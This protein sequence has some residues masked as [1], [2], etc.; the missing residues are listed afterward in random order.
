MAFGWMGM[1]TVVIATILSSWF[2]RRRG[3]AISLAF[4]GATFGGIVIAPMLVL[5]V[6]AIGFTGAMLTATAVM[7]AFLLPTIVWLID[8]PVSANTLFEP[9]AHQAAT[10]NVKAISANRSRWLLLRNFGFWTVCAPFA[11]DAG[12]NRLYRAPDCNLGANDGPLACRPRGRGHHHHGRDR[13]SL[14][15]HGG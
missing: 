12:A 11:L 9:G 5:L 13:A 7:V 2:D 1:G 3:L 14:P 4:N 6:V 10:S 15:W 8:V